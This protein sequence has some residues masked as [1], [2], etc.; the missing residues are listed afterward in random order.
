MGFRFILK[1]K[2]NK[3]TKAVVLGYTVV[4]EDLINVDLPEFKLF[5]WMLKTNFLVLIIECIL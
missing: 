3:T 5:N 4:K 1:K 2:E